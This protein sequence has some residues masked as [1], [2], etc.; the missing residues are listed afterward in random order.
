MIFIDGSRGEGGGQLLRTTLS[1]A[2]LTGTPCRVERIRAGRS[3]PGLRPQHLAVVRA[4]ALV[5]TAELEGDAIDSQTVVFRPKTPPLAGTYFFD[6]ADYASHG[7]SA[8]AVTLIFQALLWP[9]LFA[10]GPSQVTLVGGTHV[11]FSPPFHYV[12]E[13]ARPAWAQFGCRFSAELQRWGWMSAGGG[14]MAATIEPVQRL[15]AMHFERQA[16][17]TVRGIAAVTNLPSHIPQRMANRAHNRLAD[18]GVQSDIRPMRERGDGPGASIF[19]W[20]RQA[21]F[22]ALGRKGV[23][24][25][26]VAD[27]AVDDCC[28]FMDNPAAVDHHLADQLLIPMALAHGISSYTT[29]EITLHTM[30]NL[31]LLQHI[32]D[33]DYTVEGKIGRSG[34]VTVQGIGFTNSTLT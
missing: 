19:L 26:K 6:V 16:V 23:P 8:G 2:A 21:G 17:D 32:L 18:R 3:K 10:A 9:L 31:Q 25:D 12:A 24:A 11:P 29:R 1:L 13:V 27:S 15:T 14:R 22:A 33:I 30:T 34:R 4:L 5:C 20:L 28:A 7:R